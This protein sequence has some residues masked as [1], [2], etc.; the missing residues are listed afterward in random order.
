M[1]LTGSR[2]GRPSSAL[3]RPETDYVSSV[4][5]VRQPNGSVTAGRQPTA[6][7]GAGVTDSVSGL[8]RAVLYV[9][10]EKTQMK[11]TGIP[12]TGLTRRKLTPHHCRVTPGL[13][14]GQNSRQAKWLTS[15]T[16]M[17]IC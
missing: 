2:A 1:C 16:S 3:V 11:V 15:T 17:T 6:A 10:G 13:N 14:Q 8:R 4:T 7:P 9:L 12:F 5:S